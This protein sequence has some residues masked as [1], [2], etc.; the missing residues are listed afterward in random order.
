MGILLAGLQSRQ[1]AI[2]V[3]LRCITALE[4]F[5]TEYVFHCAEPDSPFSWGLLSVFRKSDQMLMQKA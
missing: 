1:I 4:A 2:T 5:L 3:G